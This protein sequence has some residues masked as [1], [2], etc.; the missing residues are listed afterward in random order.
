MW[1]AMPRGSARD[2]TAI[3][4][5]HA[6]LQVR[7]EGTSEAPVTVPRVP[8]LR[9]F[10]PS[11]GRDSFSVPL[12][13][14]PM[15]P[16]AAR[17]KQ[18]AGEILAAN[19]PNHRQKWELLWHVWQ[20]AQHPVTRSLG[21]SVNRLSLGHSVTR[22]GHCTRCQPHPKS[23]TRTPES[24]RQQ[25]Q[26]LTRTRGTGAGRQAPRPQTRPPHHTPRRGRQAMMAYRGNVWHGPRVTPM[27][28]NTTSRAQ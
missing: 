9:L 4:C 26:M 18:N 13:G 6:F 14:V 10:W 23:K 24:R 3:N 27:D 11:V 17:K 21:H 22:S 28:T 15:Q 12:G 7:V 16:Y 20:R 19:T 25:G 1:S 5:R 2:W 8:G